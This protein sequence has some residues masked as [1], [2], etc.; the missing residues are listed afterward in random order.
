MVWYWYYCLF[1]FFVVVWVCLFGVV[2]WFV[3]LMG[4][5]LGTGVVFWFANFGLGRYVM[6]WRLLR[7]CL[8]LC[9]VVWIGSGLVGCGLLLGVL[10]PVAWCVVYEIGG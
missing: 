6:C 8:L 2:F 5:L 4:L 9:F 3:G 7:G 10:W 1:V